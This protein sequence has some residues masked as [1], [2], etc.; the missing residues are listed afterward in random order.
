MQD[1]EFSNDLLHEY[2]DPGYE[3]ADPGC[4][5]QPAQPLYRPAAPEETRKRRLYIK[6]LRLLRSSLLSLAVLMLLSAAAIPQIQLT[7]PRLPADTDLVQPTPASTKAP[8]PTKVPTPTA[9]PTQQPTPVPTPA[10]PMPPPEDADLYIEPPQVQGAFVVTGHSE[11]GYA[12]QL[13]VLFPVEIRPQQDG[14]TENPWRSGGYVYTADLG[15]AELLRAPIA[16]W[17]QF[18]QRETR[19][20][21]AAEPD[22]PAYDECRF[23]YNHMA[24]AYLYPTAAGAGSDIPS[25]CCADIGAVKTT[26]DGQP[27]RSEDVVRHAYYAVCFDLSDK[28][29]QEL[30]DEELTLAIEYPDHGK[31]STVTYTYV[32][33]ALPHT[34]WQTMNLLMTGN[35]PDAD[36]A[37]YEQA[38]AEYLP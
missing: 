4:E 30:K 18:T 32:L 1:Y 5:M 29:L 16:S 31:Y 34:D 14:T 6:K 38:I 3:Y 23:L 7:L 24:L 28:K 21:A 20:A 11:D 26:A 2:A 13:C 8:A 37:A 33:S 9:A 35:A 36:R 25:L 10:E 22:N 15:A 27:P 19:R 12:N 17:S